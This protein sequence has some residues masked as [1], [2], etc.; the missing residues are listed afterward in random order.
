MPQLLCGFKMMLVTNVGVQ[1]RTALSNYSSLSDQVGS[2]KGTRPNYCR[3]HILLPPRHHPQ[4]ATLIQDPI[5]NSKILHRSQVL[6]LLLHR[7][8]ILLLV[9]NPSFIIDSQKWFLLHFTLW[10]AV[11]FFKFPT[12]LPFFDI[13][14]AHHHHKNN[15][16]CSTKT[17]QFYVRL[18]N[19]QEKKM[20]NQRLLLLKKEASYI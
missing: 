8:Q 9:P 14:F 2:V 7:N 20:E 3:Q 12:F 15:T 18:C 10:S 13:S 6:N 5:N 4:V 11:C 16:L 1:L 17:K 19:F